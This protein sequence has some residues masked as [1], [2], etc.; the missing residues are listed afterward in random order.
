MY[1]YVCAWGLHT[2]RH[3]QTDIYRH[4]DRQTYRYTGIQIYRYTDKIGTKDRMGRDGMGCNYLPH[5]HNTLYR[6][7]M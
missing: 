2:D 7:G 6:A 4:T 3:I 1:M 5:I